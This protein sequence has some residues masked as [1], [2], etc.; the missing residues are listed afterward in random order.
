M[1]YRAS[2]ACFVLLLLVTLS[3]RSNSEQVLAQ[4]SQLSSKGNFTVVSYYHA[5]TGCHPV[6]VLS[7]SIGAQPPEVLTSQVAIK[8]ISDKPVTALKL[9]WEVY[10]RKVGLKKAKAPCDA[11]PEAAD[12]Y[13]S[14]TTP[15]IQLGRLAKGEIYNIST[16]PLRINLPAAKTIFVE[17]PL[18]A[19]D[20]VKPLTV[21]GTRGTFKGD[22][23]AVLYVSEVHFEDG[24]TWEGIVK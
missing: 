4:E 3:L 20:E 21:D 23:A 24:T 14:G 7:V 1:N 9:R 5:R 18:I 12:I 11:T 15:L 19:W 13:L 22:Y 10:D 17:Q 8:G 6:A 2:N 16:N